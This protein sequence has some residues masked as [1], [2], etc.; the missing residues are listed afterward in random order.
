VLSQEE[1]LLTRFFETARLHDTT[2]L[3][4][5]A[6]VT[7]NPRTQ[8]VVQE[9]A[10]EK[11]DEGDAS[12]RVLVRA[13]VRGPDGETATKMLLVTMQRVEGRWLITELRDNP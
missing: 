3:A 2:V 12:K 8:G 10:V 13:Q 1:Q 7:F 4:K 9:F 6:T 11:V 5:Y